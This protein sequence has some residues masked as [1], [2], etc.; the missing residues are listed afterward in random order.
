M[1]Y[2][3]IEDM[4]GKFL[5]ENVR[6]MVDSMSQFSRNRFRL[7]TVSAETAKSGRII[8]VNLPEGACLDLNS[9]R[10]HFDVKTSQTGS[11]TD[12]VYAKLPQD[13]QSLIQRLE[14]N[15]NGIAV[16]QGASEWNTVYAIKKL[17]DSCIDRASSVDKALSHGDIDG[18][19]KIDIESLVI[20]DWCGFLGERS[21]RFLDTSV[22]GA[23]QV[24]I[25]L[26]N[27]AVLVP[28]QVGALNTIGK[29]LTTP[30]AKAAAEQMSYEVSNIFFTVDSVSLNPVYN[31][32]L[33]D[34]LEAEDYLPL[35]YKEQYTFSLDSIT[36]GSSS[37]R[38]SLSSGSIDK[39]YGVFRDSNYNSV[40]TVG[41]Q[42]E[43][44]GTGLGTF[45][46]NYL[47]FRSYNDTPDVDGEPAPLLAG[48][49]RYNWALN[50]CQM[51]QYSAN[52]MDALA[53][54]NYLPDKV[55][56]G[57]EGTLVTSKNSFY[58]GKFVCGQLLN[59]PCKHGVVI[60]SGFNSRGI[61]TTMNWR[62]QG[63]KIPPADVDLGTTNTI[64]S[65]V[66]LDTT[67]QLRAGVGKNLAVLF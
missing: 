19:D 2:D 37:T 33:R 20:Q 35:N 66:V 4:E 8:T 47:R 14:V 26:A 67:A 9:F 21:T 42:Y 57:G 61:N 29:K 43:N 44:A 3:E 34:R 55:G 30:A 5:P 28:K 62:V 39:M 6:Y 24:R 22:W 13:A 15:I 7:E 60:Q 50:N 48:K 40:G 54:V 11:G 58:D 1:S 52:I 12:I 38:F 17:G 56:T 36:S 63:Q 23:I 27:N 65:F 53:D 10:F 59:M 25:T 51:P 41:K 45:C 31:R 16:Q 49:L 64:G 32:M 18:T 46:A